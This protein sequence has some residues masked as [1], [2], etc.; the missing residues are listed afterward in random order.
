MTRTSICLLALVVFTQPVAAEETAP[1][2]TCLTAAYR[3]SDGS[4]L[5]ITPSNPPNLRYRTLSGETGRLYPT[6]E[7]RYESGRGWSAREPVTRHVSFGSCDDDTVRFQRQGRPALQGHKVSMP[8]NPIRFD[9]GDVSLYGELVMPA[10]NAPRVVVVLQY[11]SGRDSAVTFNF[12]QHM[13]PLK[14]IAVFVFDK[15][16]TGRSTGSYSIHIGMLARDLAAAV[17]AV[18]AH[19]ELADTPLG[20]MGESQG[21]WV[22]PLTATMLGAAEQP[23]DF[24]I[25]SY[26][27]A[28]SMLEE[29]RS[30]VV[31][32][33][34]AA[35]YGAPVLACGEELHRAAARVMLSRFNEGL[36]EL[37]RLKSAYRDAPWFDDIGGDFTSVLVSTPAG[38]MADVK[39]LFDFPYDLAYEP[40]PALEKIAVPQLW[41]LAGKDTEAPPEATLANLRELQAA[42]SP[43]EV[44]VYPD[45]E[46]GM[47][48]VEEGPDGPRLAGHYA[49]GY[50]DKLIDWILKQADP[51]RP[52]RT[53]QPAAHLRHPRAL[54]ASPADLRV[55]CR[56]GYFTPPRAPVPG[57]R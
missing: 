56:K 10:G 4:Y 3:M 28:V 39:A 31:R 34:R 30:E 8:V 46:H 47:I 14:D 24:V 21:G 22:V 49:D 2:E 15:R 53:G 44:V 41:V 40:M 1:S 7:H 26:G 33:L 52:D 6:G 55:A 48:A 32:S 9:S 50:F 38:Q 35:G 29:D 51:H 5:V 19:T 12:L 25:V 42:G 11:G 37:E 27:L 43:I 23:V 54:A 16:G 13:L 45:A 18:R 36:D 57:R 20:L 17:R